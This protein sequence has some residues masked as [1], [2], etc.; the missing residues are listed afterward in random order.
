MI[1]S[2]SSSNSIIK[3]QEYSG[4]SAFATLFWVKA[5]EE[6]GKKIFEAVR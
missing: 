2:L 6:K 5:A 1:L 3:N 4:N